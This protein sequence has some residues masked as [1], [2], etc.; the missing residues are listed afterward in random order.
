M[1]PGPKKCATK[2]VRCHL[3]WNTDWWVGALEPAVSL[4]YKCSKMLF[5]CRLKNPEEGLCSLLRD[6]SSPRQAQTGLVLLLLKSWDRELTA[7]QTQRSHESAWLAGKGRG[8][9]L[10]WQIPLYHAHSI[11]DGQYLYYMCLNYV[12]E[13]LLSNIEMC[14]TQG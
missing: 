14:I 9:R 12:F 11:R 3:G 2:G 4:Q 1:G 10:V 13:L 5:K 6:P 8:S 7:S